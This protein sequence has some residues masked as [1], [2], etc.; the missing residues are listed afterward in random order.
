MNEIATYTPTVAINSGYFCSN[1]ANMIIM[2]ATGRLSTLLNQ[3]GKAQWELHLTSRLFQLCH[4]SPIIHSFQRF[5][6]W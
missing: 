1:N 2:Q 3:I 4:G 5:K 6:N